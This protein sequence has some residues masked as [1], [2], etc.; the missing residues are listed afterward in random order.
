[1]VSG[2]I[3]VP[4][5]WVRN[6]LLDTDWFLRTASPLATDDA[7]QEAITNRVSSFVATGIANASIPTSDD[8]DRLLLI[9][10]MTMAIPAAVENVTESDGHVAAICRVVGCGS[11]NSA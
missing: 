9:T 10:T 4:T 11:Q 7:I 5:I 2:G 6:Q 3:T 1:M 8:P